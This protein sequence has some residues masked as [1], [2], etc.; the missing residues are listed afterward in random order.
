LG[1]IVPAVGIATAGTDPADLAVTKT[2]SD[3]TPNVG[4]QVTFTVMLTNN[5]PDPANGVGVTDLLPA[6]LTFVSASPSQ[7]TY[8]STAGLWTV[9]TVAVGTPQTLQLQ[10]TVVSP[11]PLTNTAAISDSDQVDPTP[12]NNTASATETP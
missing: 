3:A 2:V 9:G 4:E 5:G 6:G 8:D 1:A 7:G 10:A 11:D 12:G